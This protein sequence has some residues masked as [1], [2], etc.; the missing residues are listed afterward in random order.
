MCKMYPGSIRRG[1]LQNR[2]RRAERIPSL[3]VQL[4]SGYDSAAILLNLM[5]QYSLLGTVNNWEGETGELL[6]LLETVKPVIDLAADVESAE[7]RMAAVNRILLVIWKVLAEKIRKMEKQQQERQQEKQQ[8]QPSD[9]KEKQQE[10]QERP[11]DG[12]E[13]QECQ[14]GSSDG[15][16]KQQERQDGMSDGQEEQ[17]ERQDGS[18]D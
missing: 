6:S 7:I 1:I 5:T 17:Q 4:E 11:A 3:K 13:Q 10:K 18:P 14:D 16:E 15:K 2:V 9:G 8:E 12:Q